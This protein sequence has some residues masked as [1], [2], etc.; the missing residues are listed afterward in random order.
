[1][2]CGSF[3]GFD[4]LYINGKQFCFFLLIYTDYKAYI[5]MAEKQQIRFKERIVLLMPMVFNTFSGNYKNLHRQ[6]HN[7]NKI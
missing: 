7:S 5:R 2:F 4:L 6:K 3:I 1:M